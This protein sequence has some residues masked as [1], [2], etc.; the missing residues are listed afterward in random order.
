M[1]DAGATLNR[2]ELEERLKAIDR[3]LE[4]NPRLMD[5]FD[6]KAEMLADAGR[7]DEA[8]L[9]CNADVWLGQVPM[10]LRGRLAWIEAKAGISSK[11]CR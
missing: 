10:I 2:T 4:A 11:P 9:A 7:L 1:D 8:R 6:L 5:G 3:A